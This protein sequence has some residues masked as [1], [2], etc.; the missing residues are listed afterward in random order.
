[1]HVAVI[2]CTWQRH[3]PPTPT[4]EREHSRRRKEVSATYGLPRHTKSIFTRYNWAATKVF[5]PQGPH[6]RRRHCGDSTEITSQGPKR[7]S[8]VSSRLPLSG[9]IRKEPPPR[10]VST[11]ARNGGSPNDL[12]ARKKLQ[13]GK[14]VA[15][16]TADV[17]APTTIA[18]WKPLSPLNQKLVTRGSSARR[19]S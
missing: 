16:P 14:M 5:W 12:F 17:A 4:T 8:T 7:R 2:P 11:T 6:P 15:I 9:R 1:M 3:S 18:W 10:Q 13:A 19:R